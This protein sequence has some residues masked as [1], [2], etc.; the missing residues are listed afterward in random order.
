MRPLTTLFVL[1]LILVQLRLPFS[2]TAGD[3]PAKSVLAM[4]GALGVTSIATEGAQNLIEDSTGRLIAVYVDSSG[5]ISITYANSIPSP[6]GWSDPAKSPSPPGIVAYARPAAVLISLKSLHIIAEGGTGPG[7]VNDVAVT[8]QRDA[9][10]DIVGIAFGAPVTLDDSG[11]AANP[12]A[13]L[14]NNG[15]VLAAWSYADGQLAE[16]R[17]FRW[18]PGKG[19]MSFDGT[20][21]KRDIAVIDESNP[22]AMFPN[23]IERLDNHQVYVLGNRGNSSPSSTIV[24]NA[25]AFDGSNW[26]WGTQ[27]LSFAQDASRG[28]DD[29][30]SLAWD[31]VRT[32]IVV[33]YGT[34]GL[35]RFSVVTIDSSETLVH[36]DTPDLSLTRND[37]GGLAVD[38]QTGDYTLFFVD[39]FSNNRTGTLGLLRR[40]ENQWSNTITMVDS[41]ASNRGLSV[42]RAGTSMTT[43]IIYSKGTQS[44]TTI[45]FARIGPVQPRTLTTLNVSSSP[46]PSTLDQPVQIS[47]QLADQVN[48]EGLSGRTITIQASA[49]RG[50]WNPAVVCDPVLT[51]IEDIVGTTVN[52]DG[53][54]ARAGGRFTPIGDLDSDKRNLSPPCNVGGKPTFAEIHGVSIVWNIPTEGE[55]ETDCSKKF[56]Q[57]NGGEVYLNRVSYC[58][59]VANL[60]TPGTVGS[61]CTSVI[62]DSCLHR[63]LFE[64]DR[65][66]KAAEFCGPGTVCDDKSIRDTNSNHELIDVQGFVFWDQGHVD[67]DWHSFSGWELHPLTGWRFTG[68][69]IWKTI[70]TVRTT[71]TGSFNIS[72]SFTNSGDFF[73]RAFFSGDTSYVSA[74]SDSVKHAILDKQDTSPQRFPSI[75]QTVLFVSLV[76]VAVAVVSLTYVVLRKRT[77]EPHSQVLQSPTG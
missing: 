68:E 34:S 71:S 49:E 72:K 37:W 47:G 29:A 12:T 63:I 18:R 22:S 54:A 28:I 66:W 42:R 32:S 38:E 20:I 73:L 23:L 35:I 31:P 16:I 11:M 41:D 14:A 52:N 59:T 60:Q 17:A 9:K 21:G 5:R 33:A 69:R 74:G 8:L 55:E 58:D 7:Q 2:E 45:L 48:G 3:T 19:W 70:S 75:A 13:I 27:N 1:A 40:V 25:A 53:G 15:D 4:D 64:I 67:D 77:R 30:P 56:D 6:G 50:P 51:T 10:S 57:V 76:G 43:D 39:S 65:D 44:P 46:N 36:I 61:R 24:D 62:K 26:S